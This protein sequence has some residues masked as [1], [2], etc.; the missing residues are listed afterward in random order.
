MHNI[1]S[2]IDVNEH[3][4]VVCMH[5]KRNIN[6]GTSREEKITFTYQTH[7]S[8]QLHGI[9]S[10]GFSS[11]PQQLSRLLVERPTLAAESYFTGSPLY[12]HHETQWP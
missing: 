1:H 12:F 2:I 3:M 7:T 6:F 9:V 10:F 8:A 5:F 4:Y 11:Y